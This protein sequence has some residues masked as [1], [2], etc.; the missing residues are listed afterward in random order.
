MVLYAKL[1]RWELW[2]RY[3]WYWPN[4]YDEP[5]HVTVWYH[6]DELPKTPPFDPKSHQEWHT[7]AKF[8][9]EEDLLKWM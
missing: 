6:E 5:K 8:V 9:K 4:G 1:M 3:A 2:D 7:N